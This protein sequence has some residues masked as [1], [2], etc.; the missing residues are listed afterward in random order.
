MLKI[1]KYEKDSLSIHESEYE[2][3]CPHELE[4]QKELIELIQRNST[5]AKL[6]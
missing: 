3:N 4:C 6:I 5:Q 2:L 1:L